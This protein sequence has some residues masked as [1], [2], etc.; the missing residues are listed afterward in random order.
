MEECGYIP[1]RNP[2]AKDGMWK[3]NSRRQ[4]IYVKRELS[5][6]DGLAAARKLGEAA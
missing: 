1:I 5:D 2:H 3:I 6:R 4:V